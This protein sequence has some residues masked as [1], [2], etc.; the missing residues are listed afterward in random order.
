MA[1]TQANYPLSLDTLDTDRIAGQVVT[2]ASYDIIETAITEI[3][4]TLLSNMVYC[5]D[6]TNP[7]DAITAIGANNK[8]LLVTEAE[9]CD[10]NFTVPANVCVKFERGGRWTINTGIT[11]IFNG[12][13]DAGLWQIFTLTGTGVIKFGG[14]KVSEVLP[15]W[16]GIDGTADE[17]EINQAITAVAPSLPGNPWDIPANTYA[18]VVRLR[19]GIYN[20]A[21]TVTIPSYVKVRGSGIVN[22]KLVSSINNATIT[23]TDIAFVDGGA[24]EDTITTVAGNFVTAGFATGDRIIVTGSASNNKIYTIVEVAATTITLA[25]GVLTAEAAG[26]SVTINDSTPVITAGTFGTPAYYISLGG[27]SINGGN[28]NSTGIAIYVARW[29]LSD[30]E[31]VS[32]K[33]DG[34]YFY[35]SSIGYGYNLYAKY[36]GDSAGYAGIKLDGQGSGYGENAVSFYGGEVSSCYDG[37]IVNYGNGITFSGCTIEGNDRHGFN[38]TAGFNLSIL[39]CYFESNAVVTAGASI[40]GTLN[41]AHIDSCAFTNAGTN[42]DKCI[43]LTSGVGTTITNNMIPNI[44]SPKA[45]IGQTDETVAS[46]DFTF[47]RVSIYGNSGPSDSTPLFSANLQTCVDAKEIANPNYASTNYINHLG[48][49]RTK[50]FLKRS[51]GLYGSTSG[52]SIIKAGAVAGETTFTLPTTSGTIATNAYK[53]SAFAATTSAELAGVIS[54]ETGTD[55]LVYNTSPTLIT[56]NVGAAGGTA[57]R[58]RVR[59][60]SNYYIDLGFDTTNTGYIQ[61]ITNDV[62]G[63]LRLNEAG[64]NIG[65]GLASNAITARFHLPAGTATAS[66]APLKF[67]SGTLLTTPEAGAVEFLTDK[68][69]GTITTGAVRKTFAFLESPVFTGSISTPEKTPVNAVA[70]QGT[71]TMAGVATANETFVIDSQTFTWVA[72]RAAAGQVTIGATGAEAVTNIVTAVTADLAT[73]TA[74][75]G[76]GD[77]VIIT[78]VIKGVSGNSIVFTEASTNMTVN[79]AGTLGT[80]TAGVDG[81]VGVANEIAQ[82]ATYLYVCIATNT[83]ADTNWRRVALGSAY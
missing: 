35:N 12:Q 53:L 24:G 17:V 16:W 47:V 78:A 70:S 4:K 8:T 77:T 7:D 79:G 33:L 34:Y 6:Y 42:G 81:T 65:I 72:A 68:F 64:G 43:A 75:D 21:D 38:V 5:K 55:K 31:V 28:L 15:E 63:K 73:V 18:T 40:W 26:A 45:F 25:T 58:I 52:A 27:F 74:V 20:I 22:T 60:Y 19:S 48:V 59:R 66:T 11:V 14:G 57:D 1:K 13:I 29:E 67:T 62:G 69:Y 10:F 41:Y 30:I 32:C 44:T 80:T 3:E 49:I 50:L 83:I 56:P 51:I 39:G 46:G 61:S 23:R 76:A 2:S 36:C 54:D 37:V 82:D 9:T 71:I